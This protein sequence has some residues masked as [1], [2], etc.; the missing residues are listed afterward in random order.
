MTQGASHHHLPL[1]HILLALLVVAVWGTNF[2]VIKVALAELPPLLFACLRFTFMLVPAVFFLPRPRV[3]WRYLAAYGFLIGFGQFGIMFI[4]MER[5]ITPGLAS[6]IVQMQVFFTIGLFVWRGGER[7]R[8]FH[9]FALSLGFAGLALIMANTDGT[10]TPLGVALML[11][12]AA[13]WAG[14][15]LAARAADPAD[16]SAFVVWS[17]LFAV[18]P[19]LLLSLLF[20]GW[21]AVSAGLIGASWGVWAAVLYNA[22]AAG[23]FGFVAWGWLLQRHP[24]A[25]ITPMALL[26]P[27]FGMSVSLLWLGEPLPLWKIGAAALVISGLAVTILYPRWSDLRAPTSPG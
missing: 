2:T 25:T 16:M 9:W 7:L 17:N 6:L 26:V 19:L 1:R 20:E 10:T 14:A 4:A 23:I 12:A 22:V 13:S 15:N 8:P 27:V 21:N 3:P 18:P 24:A 11:V 5:D